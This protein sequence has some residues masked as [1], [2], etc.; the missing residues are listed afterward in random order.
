M[1]HRSTKKCEYLWLHPLLGQLGVQASKTLLGIVKNSQFE[2]AICHHPIPISLFTHS[3]NLLHFIQAFTDH[4]CPKFFLLSLAGH[5]SIGRFGL[6]LQ[7]KSRRRSP[8][9]WR[10]NPHP[11]SPPPTPTERAA[12]AAA[13]ATTKWELSSSLRRNRNDERE[14]EREIRKSADQPA[15]RVSN[16]SEVS[17]FALVPMGFSAHRSVG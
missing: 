3:L 13:A 7:P 11:P 1:Q 9:G 12:P 2:S 8:G 4:N 15:G 10:R 17:K 14:R 16:W 6:D 5:P